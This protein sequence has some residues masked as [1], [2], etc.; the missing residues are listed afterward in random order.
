MR[1]IRAQV[2]SYYSGKIERYGSTPL[3]VDWP[4]AISQYLRF[5]QLLRLCDFTK[6]FSLTDFGCG[7]GA[8]LEFLAMRHADCPVRYRGIDISP[9]MVAAAQ[10]RWSKRPDTTF[11]IGSRCSQ[12]S[13]YVLTSGT[14]NVRLGRPVPEWKRYVE[15]ILADMQRNSR[16]GFAANFMLPHDKGR[17]EQALYRTRP[18]PWIDFC[19]KQ[20][21]CEV[22]VL[23]DYGLREFTLLARCPRKPA[24][25]KAAVR[26]PSRPS[27]R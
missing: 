14:L 11:A 27:R 12:V 26:R 6:P 22:E 21:G 19:R 7:Y 5:V 16:V 17:T 8:L 15:T 25:P 2:R 10:K 13:D 23:T 9:A 1:A 24:A 20:L 4:N 3:G 18:Q